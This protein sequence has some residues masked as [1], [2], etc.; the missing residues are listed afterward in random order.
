MSDDVK[1]VIVMRNDLG[2]RKGKCVVQGSHAALKIFFDRST[3]VGSIIQIVNITKDMVT[4]VKGRFTK[5]CLRVDSE[6]EL[7]DIYQVTK[8]VGLP[9]V[10]IRDAGL[11][12]FKEPTYTCIAIGP[13][14]S[15]EIDKLTG[16]LKL[17]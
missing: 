13:A 16:H 10:I 14:K 5:I 11:T 6:E 8:E 17:L 4:W 7:F 12:E 1:M 3:Y 9:V 15:K 2:M